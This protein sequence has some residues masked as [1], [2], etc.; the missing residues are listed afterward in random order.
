VPALPVSA[1]LVAWGLRHAP[2]VGALLGAATLALSAW[3]FIG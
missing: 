3:L 2:R 1:A